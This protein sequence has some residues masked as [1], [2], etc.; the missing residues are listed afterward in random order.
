[1]AYGVYLGDRCLFHE[2]E[3]YEF[4][5]FLLDENSLEYY[6]GK[7]AHDLHKKHQLKRDLS[8]Y[9][10]D[11]EDYP[12]ILSRVKAKHLTDI[13]RAIGY[14]SHTLEKEF[15]F[16][17]KAKLETNRGSYER[18]NNRSDSAE[19]VSNILAEIEKLEPL[20]FESWKGIIQ[21]PESTNDELKFAMDLL[22]YYSDCYFILA[23]GLENADPEAE[24]VFDVTDA[25]E[26]NDELPDLIAEK[27]RICAKPIIVTEGT[28]DREFLSMA[29]DIAYP[30]LTKYIKFLDTDF[31]PESGASS[32][33]NMAK[34][35]A[36]AG[37]RDNILFLLDNDTAARSAIKSFKKSG[38]K[39][40]KNLLISQYPD[41]KSM[42]KY[43]AKGP[44]GDTLSNING[45]AGSIELYLGTNSLTIDGK[46]SPIQWKGYMDNID[47][48]QGEVLNKRQ[49]QDNFRAMVRDQNFEYVEDE[50]A[51]MK[52]LIESL[53]DDLSSLNPVQERYEDSMFSEDE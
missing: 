31:K 19:I 40:P 10:Y 1:M 33:L 43:P 48:Y 17:K 50:W 45:K 4:F 22:E 51:D 53:L 52:V 9:S 11:E 15:E 8:F 13:L 26:Y 44:D 29:I 25:T 2:R 38:I 47:D 41:T 21:N 32:I 23:V 20:T 5:L 39:L 3:D 27:D 6:K 34:N 49:V 46:L 7:R 12:L 24:V 18:F 30:H 28:T 14:G 16:I 36:S 35:F 37:F 42:S